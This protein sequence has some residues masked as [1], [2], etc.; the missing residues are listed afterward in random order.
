M[1]AVF[2]RPA[3]GKTAS[4]HRPHHAPAGLDEQPRSTTMRP[5]CLHG[6]CRRAGRGEL[7][8]T[9]LSQ[10]HLKVGCDSEMDARKEERFYLKS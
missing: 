3:A 1:N 8:F 2:L 7:T 5:A 9:V 4:A 10:C 6:N